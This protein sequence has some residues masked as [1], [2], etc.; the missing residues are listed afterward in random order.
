MSISPATW[1]K[2]LP[3]SR[4]VLLLLTLALSQTLAGQQAQ[5][6]ILDRGPLVEHGL[7]FLV[8]DTTPCYRGE[9][10]LDGVRIEIF[11]LRGEAVGADW[12]AAPCAGDVSV[13][14]FS[15]YGTVYARPLGEGQLL[16]SIPGGV[17]PCGTTA[18]FER[19]FSYFLGTTPDWYLPP[20]P[21]VV[22][23]L[24]VGALSSLPAP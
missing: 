13:R 11:Y 19:R 16:F 18:A 6:L 2:A 20:F 4:L 23:L 22:E 12:E 15:G 7:P 9:Y 14:T 17:D 21:A 24:Q 5:R 10:L 8:D 1:P 3:S